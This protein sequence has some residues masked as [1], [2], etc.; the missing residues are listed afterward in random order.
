[1]ILE[2]NKYSEWFG[3][4]ESYLEAIY[5]IFLNYSEMQ[6]EPYLKEQFYNLIYRKSSKRIPYYEKEEEIDT[7]LNEW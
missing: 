4:Y 1:M 5:A 6:D 7:E 2:D 3:I